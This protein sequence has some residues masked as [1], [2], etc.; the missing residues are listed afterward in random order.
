MRQRAVRAGGFAVA[1]LAVYGFFVLTPTGQL[2]DAASLGAFTWARELG[3]LPLFHAREVL[4]FVPIAVACAAIATAPMRGRTTDAVA[5][6]GTLVVVFALATVL[7]RMVLPRPHLG[8]FAYPENTFPSGHTAL[9]LAAIVVLAW[10]VPPRTM[11]AVLAAGGGLAVFIAIASVASFA[12]R[13]SDVVGGALLAGAVTGG[14]SRGTR[15]TSWVRRR[16][17]VIGLIALSAT[18]VV[19]FAVSAIA[20]AAG[21]DAALP[22]TT[23]LVLSSSAAVGAVLLVSAPSSAPALVPA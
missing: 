12:H 19:A 2:L 21:A 13:G 20:L 7:K 14:L 18:A 16:R 1:F 22:L 11:T 5:G 3:A 8:D 4:P 23:A 17:P 6:F 9:A 10:L 15:T